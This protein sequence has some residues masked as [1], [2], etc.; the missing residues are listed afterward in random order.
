MSP[1]LIEEFL[2]VWVGPYAVDFWTKIWLGRAR[3]TCQAYHVQIGPLSCI[4]K[5][6]ISGLP[7]A[8]AICS[9]NYHGRNI[10]RSDFRHVSFRG[11]LL[12]TSSR[13]APSPVQMTGVDGMEHVY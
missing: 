5:P 10:G 8:P 1:L 13:W 4:R 6:L 12:S 7:H 11:S 9:T 2:G 3:F